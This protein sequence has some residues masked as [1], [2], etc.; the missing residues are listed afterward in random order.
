MAYSSI[1]QASWASG[2]TAAVTGTVPCLRG[3]VDQ[4][5]VKVSDNDGGKT[6]T[7]TLTSPNGGQLFTKGTIA[8]ASTTVLKATS[9]AA[10]FDAFYIEGTLSYTITPSGDP[11]AS[12]LT[13]DVY[14]Y[15]ELL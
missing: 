15:G 14:L 6:V 5:E 8:K 2:E 10:D 3:R 13:V 7:V 1:P 9:D 12:G 4:I 11:G